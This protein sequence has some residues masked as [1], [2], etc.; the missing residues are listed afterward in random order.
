MLH[1]VKL[2]WNFK[3]LCI[4]N[5]LSYYCNVNESLIN[6][7]MLLFIIAGCCCIGLNSSGNAL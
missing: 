2:L 4:I 1:N 3:H 7:V 5:A 6:Y